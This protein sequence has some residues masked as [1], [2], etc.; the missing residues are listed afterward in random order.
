VFDCEYD[1]LGTNELD[2]ES[3][4]DMMVEKVA[5]DLP[6]LNCLQPVDYYTPAIR[7]HLLTDEYSFQKPL[8]SDI[9]LGRSDCWVVF[10]DKRVEG[11]AAQFASYASSWQGKD[12][13]G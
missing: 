12:C 5:M 11:A 13:Q 1:V 7:G 10:V 2:D 8:K 9:Q 6:W 4:L 3:K